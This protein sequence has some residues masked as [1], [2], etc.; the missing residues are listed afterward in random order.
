[1]TIR[2]NDPS[3]Y[4]HRRIK[5]PHRYRDTPDPQWTIIA[6]FSNGELY[7]DVMDWPCEPTRD[8]IA[9]YLLDVMPLSAALAAPDVEGFG[10]VAALAW[11]GYTIEKVYWSRPEQPGWGSINRAED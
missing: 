2:A 10:P 8:V 5:D 6:R 4:M 7:R 9:R 3:K 1:M 11:Y